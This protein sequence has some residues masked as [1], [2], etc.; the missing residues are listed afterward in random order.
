L[1]SKLKNKTVENN[2]W[3]DLIFTQDIHIV[4][5]TLDFVESD[6][7]WLITYRARRKLENKL[8]IG[9]LIFY[10]Y[11]AAYE[12]R[13]KP[14]LALLCANE[15]ECIPI[16]DTPDRNKFYFTILDAIKI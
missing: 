3:L 4:G 8:M 15:I 10:Y 14:K 1:M 16:T 6:L 13:I 5:L 7:W 11:P 12:S 9:N 2:S